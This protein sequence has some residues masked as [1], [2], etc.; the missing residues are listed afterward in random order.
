MGTA[1]NHD[2]GERSCGVTLSWGTADRVSPARRCAMATPWAARLAAKVRASRKASTPSTA[3]NTTPA[4]A[5]SAT[6]RPGSG[7]RTLLT[8]ATAPRGTAGRDRDAGTARSSCLAVCAAASAE[9][10]VGATTAGCASRDES[11]TPES[12][13]S[14]CPTDW[15]RSS[16]SAAV[17]ARIAALSRSGTPGTCGNG[18]QVR[19]K[20]SAS[21]R[22]WTG[23]RPESK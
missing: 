13:S 8:A 14:A 4:K 19:S 11:T 17:S 23:G 18:S 16:G 21:D 3:T 2:S 6:S 22:A 20:S 10:C 9:N 15:H 12:H 5:S 1:G 7:G